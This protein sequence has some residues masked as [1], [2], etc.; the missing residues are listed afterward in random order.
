MKD[1]VTGLNR[2]WF[3]RKLY[4]YLSQVCW[5]MVHHGGIRKLMDDDGA[6]DTITSQSKNNQNIEHTNYH[7]L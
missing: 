5:T 6:L 1:I 4:H 3:L 2:T 7:T